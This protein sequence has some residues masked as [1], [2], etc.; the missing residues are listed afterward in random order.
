[1]FVNCPF[2]DGYTALLRPLVFTVL[3]L[4]FRPRLALERSDSEETRI[5]KIVAL[6][7]SSKFGIH[8]L[9]RCQ[10]NKKGEYFRLNMPLELGI[11]MGCKLFKGG[12]WRQKRI[13]ILEKDRFRY[14]AAIS[15]L[16]GS[17]IAAHEND[18][19]EMV[20]A[21]RDWL[22]QE[23]SAPSIPAQRIYGGFLDFM[24]ENHKRLISLGWKLKHIHTIRMPELQGHMNHWL[25]QKCL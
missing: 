5:R 7:R 2:D 14:Q 19:E 16:A 22:V 8:D 15:D 4:K 1:V 12:K 10:A 18:P 17:D 13:L 21:V 25:H 23:A 6:I 24:A 3:Y 20:K 11:D 9:S